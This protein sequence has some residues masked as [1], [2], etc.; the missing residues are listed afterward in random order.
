M[1]APSK[2]YVVI[3]DTQV[4]ADSP[5]DTV[6]MT[7]YRDDV[8]HLKEVLY[9]TYT[10]AKAHTHDGVN[11]APIVPDPSSIGQG[12]LKTTT[13]TVSTSSTSPANFT[14]P[15]GTYGFYPQV[16]NNV[17]APYKTT[18][19]IATD[20]VN[21]GYVTNIVLNTS[22]GG[23]SYAKQRYIQ[24]SPPYKIGDTNWGHFLFLLREIST[25]KIISSY[26]AEDPPWAYNGKVWLPKDHTDRI[27]E[28]PHPFA[29]YT[30]KDPSADGLEIVLVNLNA[31]NTK[32]WREDNW[33]VGKGILEDLS[34]VIAG[35]GI[36]K[37][38]ADYSIPQIPRFTDKVG[39]IEP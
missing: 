38:F 17:V 15:G 34:S 30:D 29:D 3:S 16:G 35:K 20:M 36:K 14:L 6:L 37:I 26:E 25:G 10:P 5:L 1:A 28:V 24:A 33:T 27:S 23:T 19:T 18:A 8:V 31:V 7:G 32:K 21:A 39:V 11:S 22:A 12:E 4:D 9:D 13:G 2:S